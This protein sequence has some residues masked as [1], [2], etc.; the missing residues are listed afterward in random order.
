MLYYYLINFNFISA[1]IFPPI[2]IAPLTAELP[3][4]SM[5]SHSRF[6]TQ[7]LDWYFH[8]RDK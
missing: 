4:F 7:I 6:D 8:C 3:A 5:I 2:I 1:P